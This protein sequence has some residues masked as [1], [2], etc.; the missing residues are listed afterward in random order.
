MAS[1]VHQKNTPTGAYWGISP[2]LLKVIFLLAFP[3]VVFHVLRFKQ[4]QD[5]VPKK[6]QV[7]QKFPTLNP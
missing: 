6:N 4:I 7:E 2:V 5:R 1:E 3:K